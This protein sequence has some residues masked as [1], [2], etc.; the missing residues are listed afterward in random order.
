MSLRKPEAGQTVL[1]DRS[2]LIRKKRCKVPKLKISNATFL[3]IV[4]HC[5]M[6][7]F[8]CSDDCDYYFYSDSKCYCGD[9]DGTNPVPVTLSGNVDVYLKDSSKKTNSAFASCISSANAAKSASVNKKRTQGETFSYKAE[10]GRPKAGR[11]EAS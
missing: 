9:L 3:K 6:L 10:R 11:Q 1:P 5:V 8:P 7:F 2:I 4:K